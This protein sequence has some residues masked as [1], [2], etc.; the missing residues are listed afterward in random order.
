MK[1]IDE[2]TIQVHAG[3]GGDGCAS[4]RREKFIPFGGPNGG[5]GGNGGDIYLQ[6]DK[7]LNTLVHFQYQ[8]RYQAE[9]GRNGEGSQCT[10][11]SGDDL[12]VPVPMGT[13]VYEADTG[14][15]LGDLV[16]DKQQLLVAKGGRHGLGNVHFKS[17]TNQAPRRMTSGQLGEQRQLRLELRLLADVG[18]VGLPNAGKSTLIRAVSKARP[19][20]ADY[21]F[22]TLTPNL[23]VVA[24]D[25]RDSF[26]MADVPGLIEGAA[27]GSGLGIQFLKHLKRTHVLLHLIDITSQDEA[28]IVH[29]IQLIE[30]ELKKF[31]EDVYLKQRWLVFNKVDQLIAEEAE[32]VI[33]K[34]VQALH[35]QARYFTVSALS[36]AGTQDLCKAVMQY[37][38]ETRLD[39][40][41][42][43]DNNCL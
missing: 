14:E 10:G 28:A 22:T 30:N 1:F 35:W 36:G 24:V 39:P 23:G 6:A 4:F 31:S 40:A 37:L 12:I 11:R 29:D 34:A 8:K 32:L 19:R 9:R 2:V 13:M 15:Y 27:E 38:S 17:S 18:L 26:V 20:V 16:E 21:P 41:G 33:K 43:S 7:G 42:E 5:D 25:Q 3:R